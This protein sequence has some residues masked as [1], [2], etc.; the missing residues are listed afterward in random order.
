MIVRLVVLALNA[1]AR[2]GARREAMHGCEHLGRRWD[3]SVES[4]FA[5]LQGVSISIVTCFMG[6]VVHLWTRAERPRLLAGRREPVQATSVHHALV[7][8]ANGVGV[9]IG[10][11]VS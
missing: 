7:E 6:L 4:V 9:E 1:R 10:P 2:T 8:R 11:V 5:K 3:N